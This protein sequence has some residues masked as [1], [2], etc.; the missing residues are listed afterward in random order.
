VVS[1]TRQKRR[2]IRRFSR[3]IVLAKVEMSQFLMTK[4]G[5]CYESLSSDWSMAFV[6]V[7]NI[8]T[9]KQIALLVTLQ[10]LKRNVIERY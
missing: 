2:K 5:D 7:D 8:I 1:I 6:F 9:S 4:S 3:P 10:G